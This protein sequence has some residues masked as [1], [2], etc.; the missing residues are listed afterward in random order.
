VKNLDKIS[1]LQAKET[2]GKCLRE[3]YSLIEKPNQDIVD[4][5]LRVHVDENLQI[6]SPP[7]VRSPTQKRLTLV[8][9]LDETLLHYMERPEAGIHLGPDSYLS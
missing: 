7:Y 4:Q 1:F 2:I 6:V 3:D 9:D 8:L 5:N